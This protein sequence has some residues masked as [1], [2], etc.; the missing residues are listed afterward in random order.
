MADGRWTPEEARAWARIG[1][2]FLLLLLGAFLLVWQTVFAVTPQPLIV[3]AGLVVLGFPPA[4]RLG[5]KRA[6][7][8]P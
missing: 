6:G 8:E 3:G 4:L 5:E 1:R 2:D 7:D